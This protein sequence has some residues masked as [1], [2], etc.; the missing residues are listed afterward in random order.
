[1]AHFPR[2][3]SVRC[4]SGDLNFSSGH[5]TINGAWRGVG[6]WRLRVNASQPSGSERSSHTPPSTV[7]NQCGST[8]ITALLPPQATQAVEL[9]KGECLMGAFLL[10]CSRFRALHEKQAR[11]R[12]RP[13]TSGPDTAPWGTL[14]ASPAQVWPPR[15]LASAAY[16]REAVDFLSTVLSSS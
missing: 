3:F 9:N 11:H 5:Q 16:E 8:S 13:C 4:P 7:P 15:L 10:V 2:Y 6:R 12:R 14:K 1:M